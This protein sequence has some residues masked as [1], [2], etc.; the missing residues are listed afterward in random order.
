M[1]TKAPF[2]TVFSMVMFMYF[3]F[4]FIECLGHDLLWETFEIIASLAPVIKSQTYI[5]YIPILTYTENK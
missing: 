4:S 5:A 2:F 3:T 1:V